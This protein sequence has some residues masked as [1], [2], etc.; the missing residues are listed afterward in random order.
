[1]IYDINNNNN[2]ETG[3]LR[4]GGYISFRGYNIHINNM[5]CNYRRPRLSWV[6]R[7]S[8]GRFKSFRSKHSEFEVDRGPNNKCRLT[9]VSTI[10]YTISLRRTFFTLYSSAYRI[11]R[12][13]VSRRKRLTYPPHHYKISK[14]YDLKNFSPTCYTLYLCI[15]LETGGLYRVYAV[16]T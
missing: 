3:I 7:S 12:L 9:T 8:Y 11:V 16:V 13:S 1:M 6:Y 4:W 5:T 10:V 14:T 2:D 15:T